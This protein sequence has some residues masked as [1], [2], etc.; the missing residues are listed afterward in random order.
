MLLIIAACPRFDWQPFTNNCTCI[1][2]EGANDYTFLISNAARNSHPDPGEK[3]ITVTGRVDTRY[4]PT[5]LSIT[6]ICYV[7]VGSC[8]ERSTGVI[9][10]S[11]ITDPPVNTA[12][13]GMTSETSGVYTNSNDATLKSTWMTS[14]TTIYETY[15]NE[16]ISSPATQEG[17]LMTL[18]TTTSVTYSNDDIDLPST[19]SSTRL[20]SG[21]GPCFTTA[22]WRCR[23]FLAN[24]SAV[25]FETCATVGWKD[26]ES[27]W[28]LKWDRVQ[29]VGFA[30]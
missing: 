27:V 3:Q 30:I 16:G 24:G 15:S 17:S 4:K 11:G 22:T 19:T 1:F 21:T 7:G 20:L 12:A 18:G 23:K 6:M 8:S 28:S 14:K 25:F 10:S 29:D 5:D 26:C 13:S 2:G 9:P